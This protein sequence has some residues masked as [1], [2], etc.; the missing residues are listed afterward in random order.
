MR[1]APV[2][3]V[4]TFLNPDLDPSRNSLKGIRRVHSGCHL[5]GL[6]QSGLESRGW[7][8]TPRGALTNLGHS[9]FQLHG[10]SE[11]SDLH[12]LTTID[13]GKVPREAL[14]S[15]SWA[16]RIIEVDL[17]DTEVVDQNRTNHNA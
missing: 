1:N 2:S 7:P 4:S 12:D 14:I 10:S 13:L 3:K 8:G 11:R 15:V 5:I 9:L 16:S 6:V 17:A